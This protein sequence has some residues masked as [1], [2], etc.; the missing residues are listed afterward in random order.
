MP[1]QSGLRPQRPVSWYVLLAAV[2]TLIVLWNAFLV[3]IFVSFRLQRYPE[4]VALGIVLGLTAVGMLPAVEPLLARWNG[5]Q[6]LP[7]GVRDRLQSLLERVKNRAG[8]TRPIQLYVAP[9]PFI[10]AFALGRQTIIVTGGALQLP[11][12]QLEGLLAHEV[13]HLACGHTRLSLV[14]WSVSTVGGAAHRMLSAI[15][16]FFRAWGRGMAESWAVD[17]ALMGILLNIFAWSASAVLAAVNWI[18]RLAW[19]VFS[20]QMEYEADAYAAR[21]GY[22]RQLAAALAA[23]AAAGEPEDTSFLALLHS[24]HPPTAKRLKRLRALEASGAAEA[25]VALDETL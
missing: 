25:A 23:I 2:V 16:N 22:A 3:A 8:V 10:N 12:D 4:L 17:V 15:L 13:G 11:D 6:P 21:C 9:V 5:G 19:L 18:L 20:R 14:M 7:A 24:N 1:L